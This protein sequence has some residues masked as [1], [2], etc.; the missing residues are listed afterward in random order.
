MYSFLETN[1][2]YFDDFRDRSSKKRTFNKSGCKNIRTDR[3]LFNY[4]IVQKDVDVTFNYQNKVTFSTG[5][6]DSLAHHYTK[7]KR[8]T[9]R[10]K[11]NVT[12]KLRKSEA[13]LKKSS[14]SEKECESEN[15]DNCPLV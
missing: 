11:C 3:Y 2:D 13:N 15:D 1:V 9:K 10:K 12:K 6:F 7:I 14:C 4:Q 5:E 8:L